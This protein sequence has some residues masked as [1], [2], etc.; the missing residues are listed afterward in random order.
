MES[1]RRGKATIWILRAV[2]C[3]QY[4]TYTDTIHR[5]GQNCRQEQ[6]GIPYSPINAP[7]GQEMHP[8]GSTASAKGC[9]LKQTWP[10]MVKHLV[11]LDSA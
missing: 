7:Q 2:H 8:C 10:S 4:L 1:Q 5:G 6:L 3:P 9:L 11:F